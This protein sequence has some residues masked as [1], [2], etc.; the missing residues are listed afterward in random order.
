MLL[1]AMNLLSIGLILALQLSIT[2]IYNFDYIN[3]W[4]RR[5]F[6]IEKIIG[7][8]ILMIFFATSM[9]FSSLMKTAPCNLFFLNEKH[10][11][12]L[13]NKEKEKYTDLC[14]FKLNYC[15]VS[16]FSYIIFKS[17]KFKYIW[18]CMF[19]ICQICIY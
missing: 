12:D 2:N 10:L 3:I 11:H 17:G 14:L 7:I 1:V 9:L 5:V 8:F 16:F 6:V 15:V 4:G 19:P 18:I 13:R